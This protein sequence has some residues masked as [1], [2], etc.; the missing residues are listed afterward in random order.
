MA[1]LNLKCGYCKKEF[2][3]DATLVRDTSKSYCSKRCFYEFR[4]EGSLINGKKQCTTCKEIKNK[5]EFYVVPKVHRP[6]SKCK[7]CMN[8]HSRKY[9]K[10]QRNK[11][12]LLVY[13]KEYSLKQYGLS[14]EEYETLFRKQN[15]VCA[16]CGLAETRTQNGRVYAISVDHDH[17]TGKVRGLLCQKCNQAIGLFGENIN[18]VLNAA[19]YLAAA[20]KV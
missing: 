2:Q 5:S 4:H 18:N 11:A 12:K 15:G 19:K 8:A 6:F 20:E 10:E 17:R 3:R 9:F 13:N 7:L 16:I 14:L 1:L